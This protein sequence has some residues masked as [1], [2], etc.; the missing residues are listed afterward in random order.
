MF[1]IALLL[2]SFYHSNTSTRIFVAVASALLVI[3]TLWCI[4]RAWEA[5]VG[6]EV[7]FSGLLPSIT[8]AFNHARVKCHDLFVVRSFQED[9]SPRASRHDNS[10]HSTLDH[11]GGVVV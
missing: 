3:I 11:E 5:S 8:R 9:P 1:F 6:G 4:G 2:F 7:W 10:A